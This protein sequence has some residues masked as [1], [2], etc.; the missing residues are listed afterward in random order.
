MSIH[1]KLAPVF[2]FDCNVWQEY[3]HNYTGGHMYRDY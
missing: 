1:R 3:D 2:Y